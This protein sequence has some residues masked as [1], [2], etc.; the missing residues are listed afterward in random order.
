MKGKTWLILGIILIAGVIMYFVYTQSKA[1][2]TEKQNQVQVSPRAQELAAKLPY[3][4]RKNIVELY[5]RW[6]VNGDALELR[7]G[8][9]F[10]IT[11]N[12]PDQYKRT[13]IERYRMD[14]VLWSAKTN[15]NWIDGDM[16]WW[17]GH[18]KAFTLAEF[19][20]SLNVQ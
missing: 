3:G 17:L 2:V 20:E 8:I 13:S 9:V 19:K 4:T 14:G 6:R 10:N 15:Y 16:E 12:Q 1:T 5:E 18:T 7:D 11:K